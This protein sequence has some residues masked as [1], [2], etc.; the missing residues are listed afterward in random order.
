[1]TRKTAILLVVAIV[2]VGALKA[3]QDDCAER[4]CKLGEPQL[5][6][7]KCLCVTEPEN[8]HQ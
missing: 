1:M 2:A 4:R 5:V 8:E 7:A 6:A 3:A